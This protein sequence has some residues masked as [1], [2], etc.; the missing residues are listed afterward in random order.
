M[1]S[2]EERQKEQKEKEVAK[3]YQTENINVVSGK[4][5]L[6]YVEKYFI[7]GIVG[8]FALFGAYYFTHASIFVGLCVVE[9]FL[10]VFAILFSVRKDTPISYY[11][12]NLFRFL[13]KRE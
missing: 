11:V 5:H 2:L 6:S 7:A 8:F 10:W 4:F 9:I 1:K 12:K 3:M 13:S